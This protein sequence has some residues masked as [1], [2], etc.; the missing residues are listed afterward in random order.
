MKSNPYL[1]YLLVESR[2]KDSEKRFKACDDY[3]AI[4]Q[5]YEDLTGFKLDL[6][7]PKRINEKLQW[8]K[9]FYRD[10]LIPIVSDKY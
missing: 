5:G 10:D 9:L 7:D 6:S 1:F 2:R 3:T 4:I 8:L